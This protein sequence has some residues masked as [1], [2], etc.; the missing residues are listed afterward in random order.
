MW[1]PLVQPHQLPGSFLLHCTDTCSSLTA[2]CLHFPWFHAGRTLSQL[3][4]NT[5]YDYSEDYSALSSASEFALASDDYSYDYDYSPAYA[6]ATET[7]EGISIYAPGIEDF[8]IIDVPAPGYSAQEQTGTD[9][10]QGDS[11]RYWTSTHTYRE[12]T[13][14]DEEVYT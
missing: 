3:E 4:Q 1:L 6:P 5:D 7:Y 10:G 11:P 2:D 13:A 12:S 8:F 9:D 14:G